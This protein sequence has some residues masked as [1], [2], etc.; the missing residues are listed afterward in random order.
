MR[1]AV[2]FVFGVSAVVVLFPFSVRCSV[3]R[4]LVSAPPSVSFVSSV[5]FFVARW[6]AA[7]RLQLDFLAFKNMHVNMP[8][9]HRLDDVCCRWASAQYT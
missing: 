5:G 7:G 3:P 2:W 8:E 9:Q 6:S 4:A 1:A